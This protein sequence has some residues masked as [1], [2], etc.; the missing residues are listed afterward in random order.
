MDGDKSLREALH[1]IGNRNKAHNKRV[2]ANELSFS[3]MIEV[4]FFS[5]QEGNTS[6]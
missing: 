2:K 4:P 1:G 3:Y 6:Q 5:L